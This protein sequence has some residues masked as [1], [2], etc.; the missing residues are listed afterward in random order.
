[1]TLWLQTWRKYKYANTSFRPPSPLTSL[2]RL[3]IYSNITEIFTHHSWYIH[4]TFPPLLLVEIKKYLFS[5]HPVE[6]FSY[7]L[8][9]NMNTQIFKGRSV[10]HWCNISCSVSWE[11]V[12]L[13]L[14][15]STERLVLLNNVSRFHFL[16]HQTSL[17]H[18]LYWKLCH[19]KPCKHRRPSFKQIGL[20]YLTFYQ[21]SFDVILLRN[22]ENVNIGLVIVFLSKT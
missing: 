20:W 16:C 18:I 4:T 9:L 14:Q 21:I 11:S 7:I 19:L 1:M 12:S 17:H 5:V 6:W 13:V 3:K 2:S 8:L 10:T 15:I 22:C